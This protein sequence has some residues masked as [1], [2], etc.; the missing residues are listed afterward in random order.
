MLLHQ[1]WPKH[2][3]LEQSYAIPCGIPLVNM[4]KKMQHGHFGD[5]SLVM[6]LITL[7]LHFK[8][9]FSESHSDAL[10]L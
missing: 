7:Y 1:V 6:R 3:F 5:N 2:T 8:L 10:V 4:D 9:H